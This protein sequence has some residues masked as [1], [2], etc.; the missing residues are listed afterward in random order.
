MLEHTAFSLAEAGPI[1]IIA[2]IGFA[3]ATIAFFV[4]VV[5]LVRE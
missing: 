5:W 3:I 1:Q 2:F 4:W